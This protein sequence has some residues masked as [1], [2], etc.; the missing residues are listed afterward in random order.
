MRILIRSTILV[1]TVLMCMAVAEETPWCDMVNC[2]MCKCI[3]SKP[4]LMNAMSTE[5]HDISDGMMMT[6]VVAP[7]QLEAYRLAMG[8]MDAMGK[9]LQAGEQIHLCGMC[10][11]MGMLM[12]AGAKFEPVPTGFGSVEMMRGSTPETVVQIHAW[13][14]KTRTEMAKMAEAHKGEKK[15]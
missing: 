4:G 6:C 10:Q 14:E 12:A 3:S 11:G 15:H 9:R 1:L 13:A 2:D 5:V 8:E 7:G